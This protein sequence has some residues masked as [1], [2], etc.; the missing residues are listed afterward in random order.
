VGWGEAGEPSGSPL[1]R[2]VSVNTRSIVL[3]GMM[4][5]GFGA[6][7][8]C[9]L[10]WRLFGR[11]AVGLIWRMFRSIALV[12][13]D[14]QKLSIYRLGNMWKVS[15]YLTPWAGYKE[16]FCPLSCT[17]CYKCSSLGTLSP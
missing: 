16:S 4:I 14:R 17:A 3:P 5:S 6:N 11:L 15:T 8:L 12:W 10:F 13:V 2:N 9:G 1:R 7:L